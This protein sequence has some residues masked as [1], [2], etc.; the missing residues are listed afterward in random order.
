MQERRSAPRFRSDL[1]V[2]WETL[3][4]T[5]RGQVCDLSSSGCFILTGGEVH[6]RELV[7]LKIRLPQE[8]VTLW[9]NVVYAVSEMGFAVLFV[10]ESE[11]DSQLIA[12]VISSVQ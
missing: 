8:V 11:S 12:R 5:G 3:K 1:N 9:G 10:F 6:P 4:I 7:K 2:Q